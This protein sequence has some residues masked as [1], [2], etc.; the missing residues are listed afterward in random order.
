MISGL[1]LSNKEFKRGWEVDSGVLGLVFGVWRFDF[2]LVSRFGFGF[3][4]LFFV[5]CFADFHLLFVFLW[6]VTCG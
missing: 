2:V 1:G 6:F 3:L 4:G 5:F